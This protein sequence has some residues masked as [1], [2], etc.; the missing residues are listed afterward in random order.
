LIAARET[1]GHLQQII[2]EGCPLSEAVRGAL[3][4]R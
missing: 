4:A 3:E 1:F 2:V